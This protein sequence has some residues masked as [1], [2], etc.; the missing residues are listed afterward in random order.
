MAKVTKTQVV[1]FIR[2]GEKG[3]PAV[4]IIVGSDT[5]V[6][7][8]SG[9]AA[10]ITLQVFIGDRQLNYGDGT[11]DTF[12]CSTLGNS[13][14]ILDNNVYWTFKI[15]SDNK[16]FDYLLSLQNKADLSAVLPFTITVNGI[17]YSKTLTIKTVYDGTDGISVMLSQDNIVHKKSEYVSTYTINISLIDK[18]AVAPSGYSINIESFPVGITPQILQN[19][20]DG[21]KLTV[22][23]LP[24]A[25]WDTTIP[26]TLIITYGTY[27]I[28]RLV[29]VSVI[30]N[31]EKGERGAV[32]RGPQDWNELGDGYQF[33]SG[34]SGELYLDSIYYNGNFYLCKKS[35][36]KSSLNY[37]GSTT[38]NN[39]GYWQLGDKIALVA[40]TVLLA[41]YAVI[42]NLGAEGITMKDKEGNV[43]FKAE[44]GSLICK[45]GTFE[46]VD[47]S[48]IVHASLMYS[49][50]KSFN[51]QNTGSSM[52]NIDPINDPANTFYIVA[53]TGHTKFLNLPDAN[54]YG[55]LELNFYQAVLTTA[56]M[57]DIY[58]AAASS[59][60]IYYNTVGRL[61]NEN[62]VPVKI[63]P[64]S[65]DTRIK[66]SAN[67]VIRLK[68]MN[69]AWYV[70]SGLVTEE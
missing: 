17:S 65:R 13:H 37:P 22:G 53:A 42:K 32:L 2:K 10:K 48:G 28:T 5:V 62:T 50:V 46:N 38:D 15:E 23:I 11:N 69:G 40:A 20:T 45:V 68:A 51:E 19:G 61:I 7:T 52:Y 35:H 6:F 3:D 21:Y 4:N 41:E 14:Y 39:N 57:G 43:V 64:A 8:K 16:T 58:V 36:T 47:V 55:G 27:K 49:S 12:V 60:Y 34:A 44:K 70:M 67:E 63:S 1:K 54:T 66:I 29:Y 31:G 59:Q 56:A 26:I 9:Q 24:T 25:T 18:V 30:D 33:Y